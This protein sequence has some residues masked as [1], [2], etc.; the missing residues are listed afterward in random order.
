MPVLSKSKL[1]N[2]S[3]TAESLR[4]KHQM[5]PKNNGVNPIDTVISLDLSKNNLCMGSVT[6]VKHSGDCAVYKME[7]ADAGEYL[8][9]PHTQ[10][11]ITTAGNW[12]S[13]NDGHLKYGGKVA[14]YSNNELTLHTIKSLQLTNLQS[15][16]TSIRVPNRQNYILDNG[17]I[18]HTD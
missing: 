12:G 8:I 6:Y 10:F 18:V 1:I 16:Q 17:L 3:N 9:S 11:L 5:S 2:N 4:E 13:I 15:T 14:I 7:L